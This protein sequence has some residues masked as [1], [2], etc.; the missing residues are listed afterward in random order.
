MGRN[1]S[2][3]IVAAVAEGAGISFIMLEHS[4]SLRVPGA[5]YRRFAA[6]EPTLGIALAWRRGATLPTLLRLR[7]VAEEVARA[8]GSEHV[9]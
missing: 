1:Y 2:V 4:K 3:E 9:T 8:G 6:P 5:V 7:E